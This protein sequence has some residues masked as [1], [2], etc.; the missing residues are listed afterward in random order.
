[1][2]TLLDILLFPL[3]LICGLVIDGELPHDYKT[4]LSRERE[5]IAAKYGERPA[6]SSVVENQP[7]DSFYPYG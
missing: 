5:I 7:D 6:T 3:Q 2:Q 4:R 1:M